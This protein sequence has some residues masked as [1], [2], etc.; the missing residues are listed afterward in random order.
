MAL[1]S[2]FSTTLS[3]PIGIHLVLLRLVV[4]A[5]TEL[6][7]PFNVDVHLITPHNARPRPANAAALLKQEEAATSAAGAF[8]SD[9]NGSDAT[10]E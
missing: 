6:V 8:D 9:S 5:T 4:M 1:S 10:A 7:L 2:G 3:N